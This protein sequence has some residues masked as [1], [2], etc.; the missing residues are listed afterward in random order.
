MATRVLGFR[1]SFCSYHWPAFDPPALCGVEASPHA[2]V[3]VSVLRRCCCFCFLSLLLLLLLPLLLLLF[4]AEG[5]GGTAAGGG[6][7]GDGG[8]C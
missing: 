4:P 2:C 5:D 6:V 7:S 3:A 8:G 1:I